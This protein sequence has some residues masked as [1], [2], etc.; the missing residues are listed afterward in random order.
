MA[1]RIYLIGNDEKLQPLE[2]C[3]Y[4]KEAL[5]QELLARHTDLLAGEQMDPDTP[6]RWLLV[7]R[8]MDV[9]DADERA[10][11]WAIDHLFLD[12]DGVPTL[13]ETKRSTDTRLRREVAGQMLDYAANA[14]VYWPIEA[15]Q[16]S[17]ERTCSDQGK[18][19]EEVL[20][21]FLES[22]DSA[23][24]EGDVSMD[25]FWNR[26][27]TNLEAE[28]IRMVFVADKLPSELLRIV[29]FLNGQM[30]PAE[31]IAVEIKQFV[32]EGIR[33]LVPRVLGKTAKAARK[34][35]GRKQPKVQWTEETFFQ[36]LLA[37]NGPQKTQIAKQILE[38]AKQAFTEIWWGKGDTGSYV[39]VF[40]HNGRRHQP[41]A[42][43]L[44]GT[45]R[46]GFCWAKQK[47]PFDDDAKRK[48]LLAKFN[49]VDGIN[50]PEESINGKPTVP[51]ESLSSEDQY[52]PRR[53]S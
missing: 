32:G 40:V 22:G 42:V 3:P 19:P 31:V 47:P 11:R 53:R 9:P 23:E 24:D 36:R 7:A 52:R 28:R 15:I 44:N 14:V 33:T 43:K 6:R 45:V 35:G 51:L 49:A 8:E 39:P 5:L 26:V 18:D 12:Q 30:A 10:G 37:K 50:L 48:E 38:W 21:D 34:K 2:G 46:I 25:A 1:D 4:P 29:E 16:A 27:K 17:F 13:V 20:T 41:I